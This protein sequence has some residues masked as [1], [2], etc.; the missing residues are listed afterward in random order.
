MNSL[1]EGLSEK[2]RMRHHRSTLYHP[3]ANGQVERFNRT[4]CES[5][6]KQTEGV[7]DWDEFVQLT[8]FA[9][10][11]APLRSTGVTPFYLIYGRD[12]NWPPHVEVPKITLEDHVNKMIHEVPQRRSKAYDTLKQGKDHMEQRYSPK[13]PYQFQIGD[14]VWYH[15]TYKEKQYSGKLEPKWSEPMI[16]ERVLRNSTYIIGN[17]MG[18][19]K[20]PVNGDRLKLRYDRV[21][22]EPQIVINDPIPEI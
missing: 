2:F 17:E 15:K 13:K 22:M 6:A 16:V 20:V 1:I 12:P 21:E 3:Q 4:L 10:R 7:K 14:K 8:L 19:I 18:T 9:Y 11:T 5:L